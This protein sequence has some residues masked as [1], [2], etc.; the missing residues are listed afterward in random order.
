MDRQLE[1][2]LFGPDPYVEDNLAEEAKE[3]N[4]VATVALAERSRPQATSNPLGNTL[5]KEAIMGFSSLSMEDLSAFDYRHLYGPN[6]FP[7]SL[8]D[9]FELGQY[10]RLTIPLMDA[11]LA[12]L[13]LIHRDVTFLWHHEAF[14]VLVGDLRLDEDVSYLYQS[15][16]LQ[17]ILLNTLAQCL[18]MV[19]RCNDSWALVHMDATMAPIT[20]KHMLGDQ[21]QPGP[22]TP[23]TTM[24][25]RVRRILRTCQ[26]LQDDRTFTVVRPR[27]NIPV[28]NE[29][30]ADIK[31][32]WLPRRNE[33]VAPFLVFVA[34]CL[35]SQTPAR[36]I[37]D[38]LDFRAIISRFIDNIFKLCF[39]RSN[40]V[41]RPLRDLPA[42]QPPLAPRSLGDEQARD[43][44]Q[45]METDGANID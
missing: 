22:P 25:T 19:V 23:D 45:Q 36:E 26:R 31:Q 17:R 9:L 8:D 39:P 12:V 2:E 38:H 21:L 27:R 16:F 11:Q 18:F 40:R 24:D 1:E 5:R 10:G 33:D 4:E 37:S 41:L 35:V 42:L 6:R 7:V 14:K 29:M 30:Q 34:E 13:I 20:V 43:P 3:D 44:S 32:T 28:S 15:K